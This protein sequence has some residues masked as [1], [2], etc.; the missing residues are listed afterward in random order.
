MSPARCLLLFCLLSLI[1][2]APAAEDYESRVLPLMV[3]Y[4][5]D[6]HGD[7]DKPKGGANL[8]RF[9]TTA[10]TLRTLGRWLKGSAGDR[11]SGRPGLR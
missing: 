8:E 9:R 7:G 2:P 3:K 10:E 1:L 4:C 5:H 6:C 11:S